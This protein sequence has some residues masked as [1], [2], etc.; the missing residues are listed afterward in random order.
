MIKISDYLD[1]HLIAFLD[2]ASRDEA[3][4]ALIEIAYNA[5]KLR[6]KYAF[7]EAI[8][9]REKIVSTGIGMGTAIPHAKLASYDN[10]FIVV[11][12]LNKGL[13]W[14]AIDGSPVRFIFLIGGPDDKQTEYLQ[15]L[16]GLTQ[17]IKE[18]KIRKKMLTLKFPEDMI[19]VFKQC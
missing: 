1:P 4:K 2:V 5:G 11:G 9:D 15:I 10:F 16:S 8:I 13:D 3:I 14:N 17:A 18:D 6:D 12:I 19:E 7:Y